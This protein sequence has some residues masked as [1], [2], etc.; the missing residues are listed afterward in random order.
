V[1]QTTPYQEGDYRTKPCMLGQAGHA[2]EK[3]IARDDP[4]RASSLSQAR[5]RAGKTA[6]L[7]ARA[8]GRR[9]RGVGRRCAEQ[10][11]PTSLHPFSRAEPAYRRAG[12]PGA[13]SRSGVLNGEDQFS[14]VS[15]R[16]GVEPLPTTQ[17]PTYATS[18]A[19]VRSAAWP[20]V[21]RWAPR[22]PQSSKIDA[23]EVAAAGSLL[24]FSQYSAPV[25]SGA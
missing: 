4:P 12:M 9:A 23:S 14:S 7:Q 22:T 8:G 10:G 17:A 18:L 20:K 3:Q 24:F 11:H 25:R 13:A 5:E 15:R 6:A 21:R 1:I 19:N 2:L 16:L